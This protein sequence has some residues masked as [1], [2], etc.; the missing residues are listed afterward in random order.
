[1][2]KL[3]RN[4]RFK[5]RRLACLF[6]VALTLVPL[7][8]GCGDRGQLRSQ[9]WSSGIASLPQRTTTLKAH[10]HDGSVLVFSSWALAR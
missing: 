9:V 8:S 6:A 5:L 2:V 1:M 3:T 4:C 7:S 10:L